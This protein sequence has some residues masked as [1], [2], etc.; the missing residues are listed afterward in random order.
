V[1]SIVRPPLTAVI[2]SIDFYAASI[3]PFSSASKALT[4][5]LAAQ[6]GGPIG[7]AGGAAAETIAARAHAR[8]RIAD[9]RIEISFCFRYGVCGSRLLAPDGDR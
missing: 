9:L 4:S 8:T 1:F 2:A 6:I 3:R 7:T 5:G